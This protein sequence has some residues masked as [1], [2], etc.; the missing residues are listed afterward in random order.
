[1][2]VAPGWARGR[3]KL[4]FNGYRVSGFVFQLLFLSGLAIKA[5]A[6]HMLG[7]CSGAEL[8]PQP[9]SFSLAN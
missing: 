7:K 6:S 8:E 1:M 3:R 4:L 9:Q 2:V 5:K